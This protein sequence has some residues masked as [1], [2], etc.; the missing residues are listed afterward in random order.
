MVLWQCAKNPPEAG[1]VFGSH[2]WVLEPNGVA[3][4]F[5]EKIGFSLE[6]GIEKTLERGT[7]TV[8]AVR[9][10]LTI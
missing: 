4:A 1:G 10:R 9:Y 5:Y 7:T 3:W 2:L 8:R 6:R